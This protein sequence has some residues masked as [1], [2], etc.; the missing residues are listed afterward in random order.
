MRRLIVITI[1]SLTL[2]LDSNAQFVE[3]YGNYVYSS[4]HYEYQYI[5]HYKSFRT[6]SF[7]LNYYLREDRKLNFLVGIS[8]DQKGAD[9]IQSLVTPVSLRFDF[10]SLKGLA[11][12]KIG[13]LNELQFGPYVAFLTDIE[14]TPVRIGSSGGYLAEYRNKELG[15][16]LVFERTISWFEQFETMLRGEANYG[17]TTIWG[18][19][20]FLHLYNFDR[21]ITFGVGV[22][23]RWHYNKKE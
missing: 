2:N 22:A 18:Q 6:S 15:F 20:D 10:L 11:R 19:E 5:N 1:L 14:I 7:G 17:L 4:M 16:S 12:C 21:N 3:V 23:I 13:S 8:Y 9:Y